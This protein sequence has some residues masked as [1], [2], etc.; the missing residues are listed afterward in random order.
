MKIPIDESTMEH[1]F[2]E[3]LVSPKKG[4][5]DQTGM[6]VENIMMATLIK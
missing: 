1:Q 4:T 5:I 3:M 6:E 2:N